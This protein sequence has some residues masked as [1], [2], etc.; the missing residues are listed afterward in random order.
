[1]LLKVTHMWFLFSSQQCKEH[2]W[3]LYDRVSGNG[4]R[5]RGAVLHPRLPQTTR[6]TL[7]G[8]VT[9]WTQWPAGHHP[10]IPCQRPPARQ[11]LQAMSRGVV[12]LCYWD[13]CSETRM[14]GT[15]QLP[16]FSREPGMA[17]CW[18]DQV[19]CVCMYICVT[20]RFRRTCGAIEKCE[21]GGWG[22]RNKHQE[23]LLSGLLPDTS[24]DVTRAIHHCLGCCIGHRAPHCGAGHESEGIQ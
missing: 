8:D 10:R 6:P 4:L 13:D 2:D 5:L 16:Y 9:G 22:R 11:Q 1:M 12:Q 14:D 21:A 19:Q 7:P 3:S 24:W 20:L 23:I 17:V 15:H 18:I